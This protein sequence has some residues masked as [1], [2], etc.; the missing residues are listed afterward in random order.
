[1]ETQ[2][3]II[4]EGVTMKYRVVFTGIASLLLAIMLALSGC[5]S[6]TDNGGGSS[7]SAVTASVISGV[8]APATGGIAAVTI[9]ETAQFTGTVSWT[10]QP[11]GGTF[12]ANTAYTATITLT[13]KA[14]YTFDGVTANFFTVPGATTTTNAA[15][16]GTV[17]A[18]FPSTDSAVTT[19]VIS[20]VN[21]PATGGTAAVTITET[22]QF[23]GTV[24]WT[25][26]PAGGTFSA[27]T[28]YTATITLTAKS[29]YIFN[30]VTANFFTVPGATTTTNAANSGTIT[31]VFPS[32]AAPAVN[33]VPAVNDSVANDAATLGLVGT[34]VSS[35]ATAVAAAAIDGGKIKITSASAGSATITVSDAANH[36][37]TIQVTVA[38]SGSITIGTI[39]KYEST[40]P[41]LGAWRI[42][43]TTNFESLIIF[44]D[45]FIYYTAPTKQR[46]PIDW[47]NRTI[48]LAVPG[49]SNGAEK[50]YQVEL[51]ATNKL[52]IKQS[53]FKDADGKAIDVTFTRIEGSARTDV[54][55]VWYSWDQR[56]DPLYTLLVIRPTTNTVYASFGAVPGSWDWTKV[57]WLR[58]A[59]E[60]VGVDT[61][62]GI[63]YIAWGDGSGRTMNYTLEGNELT[64]V[65]SDGPYTYTKQN[66]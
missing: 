61:T 37:A 51:N 34:S 23:T 57:Q 13:A 28:V 4:M 5:P 49:I 54:Y 39:T 3:P 6:P 21:A 32:T 26:Q 59:Y 27:N 29:G 42:G 24:S 25:P 11:A 33:F 8:N 62:T 7:D 47:P 31:A 14:G 9:T 58:S 48:K 46:S 20:G 64:I 44:T 60:L 15:N 63:G 40:N 43:T 50:D 38:A 52:V 41:L 10:P 55:D 18:V 56:T 12:A 45:D 36:N 30:G 53:Y 19:S 2:K 35:S 17:I 65:F 16:S 66:L 22:A 1:V